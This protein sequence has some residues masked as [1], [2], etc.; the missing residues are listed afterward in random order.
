MHG[1]RVIIGTFLRDHVETHM[2]R[3][4]DVKAQ[5]LRVESVHHEQGVRRI[6]KED[7]DHEH[8]QPDKQVPLALVP[9]LF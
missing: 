7:R 5:G 4:L 2:I 3:M 8:F 9:E 1:G 6:P